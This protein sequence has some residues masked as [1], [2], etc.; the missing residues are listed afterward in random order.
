[1]YHS[2][3]FGAH[4]DITEQLLDYLLH[5]SSAQCRWLLQIERTLSV[6]NAN[7]IHLLTILRFWTRDAVTISRS[8][9]GQDKALC[10]TPVSLIA[11]LISMLWGKIDCDLI[12]STTLI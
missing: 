9:T 2:G 6:G 7:R 11:T 3:L 10:T 5:C 1:M 4:P 8:A 12:A